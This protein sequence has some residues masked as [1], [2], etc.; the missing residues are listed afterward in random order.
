[1]QKRFLHHAPDRDSRVT[2]SSYTTKLLPPP[3]ITFMDCGL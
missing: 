1:M 2:R 3:P